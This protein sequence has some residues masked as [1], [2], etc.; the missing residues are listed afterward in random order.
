M[1]N[2]ASTFVCVDVSAL[3]CSLDTEEHFF[4]IFSQAHNVALEVPRGSS[5]L[6]YLTYGGFLTGESYKTAV[7]VGHLYVPDSEFMQPSSF[8]CA[9]WSVAE[10]SGS[11]VWLQC[12]ADTC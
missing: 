2:V 3:M 12:I 5:A 4:P 10:P 1:V 6:I 9:Q 7:K 8:H 11:Y